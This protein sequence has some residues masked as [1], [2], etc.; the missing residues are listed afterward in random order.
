MSTQVGQQTP[1]NST[2][3]QA[4]SQQ[5]AAQHALL[6]QQSAGNHAGGQSMNASWPIPAQITR[7]SIQEMIQVRG[8]LEVA[9]VIEMDRVEERAWL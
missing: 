4:T 6:L 7:E 8:V 9:K 3:Q 2:L 5:Q 1:Q